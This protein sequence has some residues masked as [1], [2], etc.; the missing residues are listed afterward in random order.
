[1]IEFSTIQTLICAGKAGQN[2]H[3]LITYAHLN[4][5]QR[6]QLQSQ[7]RK[8]F[9]VMTLNSIDLQL[10][11]KSWTDPT[12]QCVWGQDFCYYKGVCL[13]GCCW[14]APVG[15]LVS[16]CQ[17]L[18]QLFARLLQLLPRH[19]D[20]II[21]SVKCLSEL[22]A[23]IVSNPWIFGFANVSD[24]IFIYYLQELINNFDCIAEYLQPMMLN[25]TER[26]SLYYK[27]IGTVTISGKLL[28]T[29]KVQDCRLGLT[30]E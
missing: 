28:N 20:N 15:H 12:T 17:R 22:Q 14:L 2:C 16:V 13:F 18:P 11:S 21:R 19:F 5:K 27:P 1:M 8:V 10:S 26:F 29:G 3:P 23:A 24:N 7:C 25:R 6:S 30:A 4:S 9:D